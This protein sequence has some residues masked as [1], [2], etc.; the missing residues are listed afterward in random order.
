MLLEGDRALE[1]FDQPCAKA[2]HFI[3]LAWPAQYDDELVTAQACHQVG[4]TGHLP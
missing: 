3:M 4:V 1:R 2:V